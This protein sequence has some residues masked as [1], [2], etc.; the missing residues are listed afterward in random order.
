MNLTVELADE[1]PVDLPL[2]GAIRPGARR[3][4]CWPNST[5]MT[6]SANPN[7]KSLAG[8]ET[9]CELDGFLK[10]HDIWIGYTRETGNANAR[11]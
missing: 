6:G 9:G 11:A 4:H 3:R 10:A 2:R 7:C 1:S 5:S 8:I